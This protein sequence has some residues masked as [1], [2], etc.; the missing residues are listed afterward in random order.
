MKS[1]Y[2]NELKIGQTVKEK[3]LLTRKNLKEKKDGGFYTQTEFADR[4]GA[5]EGIAWDDASEDLKELSIGDFVFIVGSVSEYNGRLQIV[6][7]S[8]RKVAEDEIDPDDFLPRA[9]E[10]I[11][12]VMEEI[13][14]Y[15]KRIK[16]SYLKNLVELFFLDTT[17][18]EKFCRAPAAKKA[19]HAYIGGLALHTRNILRLIN[20]IQ[21]S[22]NFLNFD[23]L[24]TAGFLH[25]IGKI[26]EYNYHKKIE[27]STI[28]KMLGHII[29]GYQ[30]VS[31][32]IDRISG[33]PEDLKLKILHMILSHHGELEWGSPIVPCFPEALV[34]HFID[35]LDSKMEMMREASKQKRGEDKEWSDYHPLLEREIYLKEEG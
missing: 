4:T 28:G 18:L 9:E 3:F 30:M 34:L 31:Q 32:K 2:V 10:D 25:D 8:I 11:G 20:G 7:S 33:F 13:E 24:L 12:S 19:H 1:Q 27:Y 5:I 22:Y 16:N 6:V 29:I 17:F 14:T 15:R 26:Y 35:N 23:L 21:N